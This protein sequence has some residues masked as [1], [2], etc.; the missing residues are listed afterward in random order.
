[1]GDI[2]EEYSKDAHFHNMWENLRLFIIRTDKGYIS[3]ENYD[4]QL[5]KYK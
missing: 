5:G 4:F 2:K 3:K 1:M